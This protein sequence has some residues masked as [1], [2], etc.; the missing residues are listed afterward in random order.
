MKQMGRLR[1]E[2]A[3]HSGGLPGANPRDSRMQDGSWN[4]EQMGAGWEPSSFGVVL[5]P[6]AAL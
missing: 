6:E 5:L 3:T 1:G 4:R 2:G